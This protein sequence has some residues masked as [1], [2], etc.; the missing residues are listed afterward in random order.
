MYKP[1]PLIWTARSAI[2]CPT[3][4]AAANATRAHMGLPP[5]PQHIVESYVGDGLA[6]LVHRVLNRQA[7]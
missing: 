4:P 1:L 6:D 5:L 2:L 3:W 7:R